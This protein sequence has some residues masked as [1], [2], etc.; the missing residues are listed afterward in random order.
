[1]FNQIKT[2]K[3]N[4]DIVAQLTRKLNLGTENIIARMALTYSLSK[5]NMFSLNDISDSGGKEYSRFV[6]FGDY[7]ELYVGLICTHY[8]IYKTDK[9]LGKYV[10]LHIDDGLHLINEELQKVNNI[11]GF[12]FLV[13]LISSNLNN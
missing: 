4:K 1:M 5:N 7:D 10:K 13:E 9:D 3:T 8:G 2:N 11:D 6:L 12:D